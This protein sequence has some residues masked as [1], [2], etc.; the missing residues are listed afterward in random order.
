MHVTNEIT[1][2]T[3]TVLQYKKLSFIDD[4]VKAIKFGSNRIKDV[5]TVILSVCSDGK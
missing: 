1:T 5:T 3:S 4:D 2:K